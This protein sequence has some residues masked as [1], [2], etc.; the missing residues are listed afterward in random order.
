MIN[1]QKRTGSRG[2]HC[3]QVNIRPQS[4]LIPYLGRPTKQ[5][6]NQLLRESHNVAGGTDEEVDDDDD[7]DDDDDGDDDDDD[8]PFAYKSR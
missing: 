1:N 6:Y 8:G 5:H 7:D 2:S 3:T 4:V